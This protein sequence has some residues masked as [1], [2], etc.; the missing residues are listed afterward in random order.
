MSM[1][2]TSKRELIVI[3]SVEPTGWLSTNKCAGGG[4]PPL[5]TVNSGDGTITDEDDITLSEPKRGAFEIL[6]GKTTVSFKLEPDKID[7]QDV[8]GVKDYTRGHD[9]YSGQF[10]FE[11][12]KNSNRIQSAVDGY[13]DPDTLMSEPYDDFRLFE[14]W[15][16]VNPKNANGEC[17]FSRDAVKCDTLVKHYYV[18]MDSLDETRE[19]PNKLTV[20]ISRRWFQ[21]FKNVEF[22][23][24][25]LVFYTATSQVAG[26]YTP[27]ASTEQPRE[28][29]RIWCNITSGTMGTIKLYG[30]N[31][32]G[33]PVTE[34][35]SVASK[36][37][38]GDIVGHVYFA[39]LDR[40]VTSTTLSYTLKDFD[41][42]LKNP[43]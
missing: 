17:D 20:P 6:M 28:H 25:A 9:T 37:A 34:T 4:I 23:T 24:T 21:R 30:R 35:L 13:W 19:I 8:A 29:T 1:K 11:Q 42:G 38:A 15:T 2:Q 18:I 3:K 12:L 26:T 33:E 41:F 43:L 32:L 10:E 27:N 31:L 39:N 16:V 7:N 40:I 36:S 14:I 5:G 22:P